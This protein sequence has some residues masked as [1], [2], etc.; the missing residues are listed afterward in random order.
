ML[1]LTCAKLRAEIAFKKLN[2]LTPS[3]GSYLYELYGVATN[4]DISNDE[5]DAA[6]TDL[7]NELRQLSLTVTDYEVYLW[8]C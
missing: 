5:R 3:A 6:F 7:Q 1:N 2:D 8:D 4:P